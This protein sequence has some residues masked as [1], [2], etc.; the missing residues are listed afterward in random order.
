MKPHSARRWSCL[1]LLAAAGPAAAQGP[2]G[3]RSGTP[4][5]EAQRWTL[6][7]GDAAASGLF[8]SAV[9]GQDV[10][11]LADGP[12]ASGGVDFA[13]PADRAT[14]QDLDTR[15]LAFGEGFVLLRGEAVGDGRVAGLDSAASLS[16]RDI[17]PVSFHTV[18]E[19]AT[20]AVLLGGVGVLAARRRQ[21]GPD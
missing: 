4:S 15:L 7:F 14:V 13:G 19:P 3:E 17:G 2:A 10:A 18:P 20:L 6:Y 8:D 11:R 9:G 1:A 12:V 16:V 21:G 5:T